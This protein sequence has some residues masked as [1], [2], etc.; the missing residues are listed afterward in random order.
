MIIV[1]GISRIHITLIDMNGEL[2]RIDGGV[3]FAIESPRVVTEIREGKCDEEESILLIKHR[4]K[5]KTGL[6]TEN[7]CV[8]VVETFDKHVGLGF[9][10]Q[11]SMAVAYGILTY[12]N[13][14]INY[15]DIAKI[16][17]RGGTSGIGVHAFKYGGFIMDLGHK[18]TE[19]NG[20]LPSDFSMASPPPLLTRLPMPEWLVVILIHK[21]VRRFM[22]RKRL[23]SSGNIIL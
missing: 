3:G 5:E 21:K 7:I 12:L 15:I 6:N 13:V 1:N 20:P 22:G 19:K 18:I 14:E 11:F 2:G 10:T 8:K 23:T 9:T 4:I 17:G 16:V